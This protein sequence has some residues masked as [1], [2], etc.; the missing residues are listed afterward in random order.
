MVIYFDKFWLRMTALFIGLLFFQNNQ[1]I[2]KILIHRNMEDKNSTII[3]MK[4][5]FSF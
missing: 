2:V 1:S 5:E 3:I 4:S